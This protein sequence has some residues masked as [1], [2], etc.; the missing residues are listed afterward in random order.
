MG[1]KNIP[2]CRFPKEEVKTKTLVA[3]DFDG[4]LTAKDSLWKFLLFTHTPIRAAWNMLLLSPYLCLC[5]LRIVSND[6]AKEKLIARFYKNME[7]TRFNAIC[8]SFYPIINRFIRTEVVREMKQHLDNGHKV[9]IVSASIENWIQPW[10]DHNG[11]DTVIATRLEVDPAGKLTG[12]FASPNCNGGEKVRRILALY[13]DRD[14][15]TLIAY[16]NGRGD[17]AM[18]QVADQKHLVS[19]RR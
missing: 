16:G 17:R 10:A 12:R 15:Y 1:G 8:L 18:L 6:K 9:V 11:I 3:F 14:N 4:T 19:N 7:V 13:P 2:A 5:A